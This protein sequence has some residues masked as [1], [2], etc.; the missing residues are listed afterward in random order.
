MAFLCLYWFSNM[1]S[2]DHWFRGQSTDKFHYMGVRSDDREATA[3]WFFLP[4][5]IPTHWEDPVLLSQ[6]PSV[7]R[8]CYR[9]DD[10][11]SEFRCVP[12][13]W[14]GE[15]AFWFRRGE[16]NGH[17]TLPL[18]TCVGGQEVFPEWLRRKLFSIFQTD[19]FRSFSPSW[20]SQT[21]LY[22]SVLPSG[23]VRQQTKI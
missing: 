19:I 3:L 2:D 18:A 23:S 15:E 4:E 5:D 6:E 20:C 16:E 11:V 14:W 8:R 1:F 12:S 7:L 13:I 21:Q 10:G 17:Q 9:S 22:V